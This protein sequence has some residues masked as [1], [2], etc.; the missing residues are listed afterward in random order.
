MATMTQYVLRELVK[1]F[2]Y[3]LVALTGAMLV[4]GVVQEAL[5][6]GLPPAQILRLVP[7]ILPGTLRV[8]VP[9]ALLLGTTSLY[10]RMSGCNEVVAIKALGIS[11][12]AIL[13]PAL[14][15]A[16]L[17]SFVTVWLNDV[18]VSWGRL[19]VQ[20]VVLEGVEEIVY[21]IL[22]TEGCYSTPRLSV[23]VKGIDGRRLISPIVTI[24]ARGDAPAMEMGAREATLEADPAQNVLKVILR[25]G[26]YE[27]GKGLAMRNPD[28]QELP[29]PLSEASRADERSDNPSCLPLWRIPS[30]VAAQQDAI[31][32]HDEELAATAAFQML[33]GDFDGATGAEWGRR[34][35]EAAEMR[36][37]LCRLQTEPYRRWSAGFSCLFFVW[38]GAPI[39]IWLRN[40]DFLTS[41][42]LC[43]LPILAVY[44]PLLMLGEDLSTSG[45]LPHVDRE[46]ITRVRNQFADSPTTETLERLQHTA[47]SLVFWVDGKF[48]PIDRLGRVI[49]MAIGNEGAGFVTPV[50]VGRDGAFYFARVLERERG[51]PKAF[52]EVR[53]Q[54]RTELREQRRERLL[55]SLYGKGVFK[56]MI[57]D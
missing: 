19:G 33:T 54:L 3:A 49:E 27:I 25:N 8:A 5:K 24:A 30:E 20:R 57:P 21:G 46:L 18:A 48:G 15:V 9:V 56:R 29:I 40:K 28:V 4:V 50:F 52:E 12:V 7:Y 43:F 34:E 35:A 32:R 2:L 26:W 44:Y 42:F 1:V 14:A 16:C 53:E 17:L 22:R 51:K 55:E 38:V 23:T 11:P 37:R 41:F 13:W 36:S 45:T 31:Q 6:Q 39:A 10:S 47:P